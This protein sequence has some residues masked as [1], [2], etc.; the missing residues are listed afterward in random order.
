MDLSQLA[1]IEGPGLVLRLIRPEDADYLHTLRTDPNYNE[2]LSAVSGSAQDQRDWIESYM[3]REANG[4]ELYY[5]IERKDGVRCGF[6]RLYDIT[7]DSFTWGSWIL[8]ANKPPKAALESA[9]LSFGVGFDHLQIPKALVD[10]RVGNER[11]LS[12]Y[13]RLGMTELRRD[14]QDIYFTYTQKKFAV[15][16]P[17][18]MKLVHQEAKS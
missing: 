2:H 5:V 9:M 13:I 15:D 14:K 10:V 7:A 4:L 16:R 18:Y 1:R 17:F 6:V 11:A 8:D 12:F 3:T